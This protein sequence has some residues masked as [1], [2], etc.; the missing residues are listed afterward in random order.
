M[1]KEHEKLTNMLENGKISEEDYKL[2]SQA[3]NKKSL[4]NKLENSLLINPYQKIA[5]IKA[6]SLGLLMMVFMSITGVYANIYFDGIFG[7]IFAEHLKAMRPD[8]LLLMYQNSIAIFVLANMF[9]MGALILKQK[10]IRIIDFF[11]TV[12]LSRYPLLIWLLYSLLE[13]HVFPH[14]PIDYSKDIELHFSITATF[15]YFVMFGTFGWQVMTS[16]FA[17]KESS[18]VEGRGL[19]VS[20]IFILLISDM[21]S[22]PLSRWFL[23]S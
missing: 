20:F 1:S 14:N 5:G 6:L 18:G 19:W 15:S 7:F 2:L 16:F 13:K 9:L 12:A 8:F 23:Y 4:S 22:I 11:G 17:Y 10:R 3:L 21:I